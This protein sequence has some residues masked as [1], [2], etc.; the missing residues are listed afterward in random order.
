MVAVVG[1]HDDNLRTKRHSLRLTS[2][3]A[4]MKS[5]YVARMMIAPS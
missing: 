3:F 2:L 1:P 5:L 4:E